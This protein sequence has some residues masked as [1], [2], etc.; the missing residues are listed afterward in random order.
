VSE[1]EFQFICHCIIPHASKPRVLLVCKPSGEWEL[2]S[3]RISPDYWS[4]D[5][6]GRLSEQL[7]AHVGIQAT[8]LRQVWM[9]PPDLVS[10]FENRSPASA[11]AP[12]QR[13][14][15]RGELTT[16]NVVCPGGRQLLESWLAETESGEIPP[17]RAPWERRGWRAEAERWIRAELSRLGEQ[18]VGPVQQIKGGWPDS[19]VLRVPTRR[20]N[21]YFKADSAQP[22]SE[23]ELTAALA[24]RWPGSVPEIVVMD[25]ARSWMLTRDFGS[26][27]LEVDPGTPRCPRYHV[28][29]ARCALSRSCRSR[30]A[31][32][33]TR[34]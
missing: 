34:G 20:G 12:D 27:Q 6:L 8:L 13:W 30:L 15:S 28:G 22:P 23:P 7:R 21:L 24:A 4:P 19:C 25:K 29:R 1:S 26:Q 11:L 16:L 3:V 9:E 33:S 32:T 18:P 2:P 14:V 31:R 5:W 17:A 10:E